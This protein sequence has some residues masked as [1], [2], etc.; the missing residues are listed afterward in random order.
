LKTLFT[1][2]GILFFAINLQAQ[3]IRT[4]RTQVEQGSLLVM[5]ID[6]RWRVPALQ[7]SAISIFGQRYLPNDRGDVFIG[8]G[9]DK[10]GK[11]NACLVDYGNGAFLSA[12]VVEIEVIKAEFPKTRTAS[13]SGQPVLR[14]G[15]EV[16]AIH[17]VFAEANKMTAD[18]TSGQFTMPLSS[19]YGIIDTFGFIYNN[20]LYK[21]HRGVDYRVPVGTSV[22]ATNS[23]VVVMTAHRFS[24]EGNMIIIYH[25]RGIFSVYMHL[26]KI[27][28][29]NGQK[30]VNGEQIGLSG[31][32]GLGVR[33]PH[34]HFN[35][36]VGED[37]IDP[38]KFINTANLYLK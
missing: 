7:N 22:R 6:A 17:K 12:D 24:L 3:S 13:Y 36:R 34:L 32:T 19:H 37:Y 15:P 28:V 14:T 33:E 9:L 38:E 25:G 18:L 31:R 10:L 8:V 1:L 20:S 11:Y 27:I 4:Y 2:F 23:G 26:S 29:K 16:S 30:I 5:S 21:Q 35:I